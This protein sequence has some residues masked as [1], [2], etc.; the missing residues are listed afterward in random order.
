MPLTHLAMAFTTAHPGVSSAL[1]GV[2]TMEHLDDVLAGLDVVLADD[3]LDRIDS[4]V[5]PGTDVG[6]LDQDCV[7]P[8][9]QDPDLRRRP[10]HQRSA[11]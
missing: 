3:I 10:M 9:L 1:I 6:K 11:A 5:A 4:I 8:A 2:R 7:R